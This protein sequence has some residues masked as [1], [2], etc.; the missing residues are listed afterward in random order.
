MGNSICPVLRI[1]Y[2]TEN[3]KKTRVKINSTS[4]D[5]TW[6][7]P[8][9]TELAEIMNWNEIW[10]P[11][12][13]LIEMNMNNDWMN[14]WMYEWMNKL[15]WGLRTLVLTG[16][17]HFKLWLLYNS[18]INLPPTVMV[19]GAIFISMDSTQLPLTPIIIWKH[20]NCYLFITIIIQFVPSIQS[21]WIWSWNFESDHQ[22]HLHHQRHVKKT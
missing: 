12:W 4:M 8:N 18:Y 20:V 16:L 2:E 5:D 17:L 3:G 21:I 15:F 11:K 1:E 13:D 7:R 14:E 10:F 19:N 22:H 9:E 6:Q